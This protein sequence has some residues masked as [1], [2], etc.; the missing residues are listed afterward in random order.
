MRQDKTVLIPN[1]GWF[2]PE[3]MDLGLIVQLQGRGLTCNVYFTT[4]C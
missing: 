1:T 2:C 3:D 4:N